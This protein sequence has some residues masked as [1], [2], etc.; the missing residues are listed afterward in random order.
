MNYV[1]GQNMQSA[2]LAQA[3]AAYEQAAA[4]A[5]I[6]AKIAEMTG[7]YNQWLNQYLENKRAERARKH[8][9]EVAKIEADRKAYD[10]RQAA[11]KAAAIKAATPGPVGTTVVKP[12]AVVALTGGAALTNVSSKI[13]VPGAVWNSSDG[14]DAPTAAVGGAIAATGAMEVA[15]TGDP[16]EDPD[17]DCNDPRKLVEDMA[18]EVI[19]DWGMSGLDQRI[20]AEQWKHPEYIWAYRGSEVHKEVGRRLGRRYPDLFRR[21][22][23]RQRPRLHRE[24]R[25]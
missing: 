1:Y 21:H 6:N 16:G 13:Q 23:E 8:A 20:T 24:D 14:T 22:D 7:A 19:E 4:Q 18:K 9:E 15:G 17:G 11:E 10:I 3:W 5:R 2:S 12:P 25:R